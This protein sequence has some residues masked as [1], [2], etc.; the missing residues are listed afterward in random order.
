VANRFDHSPRAEAAIS[1]TS[2]Y[3]HLFNAFVFLSTLMFFQ[4]MAKAEIER[5]MLS[6]AEVKRIVSEK[7]PSFSKNNC[8]LECV[9]ASLAELMNPSK[10]LIDADQYMETLELCESENTNTL[11]ENENPK[12][13]TQTEGRPQL[14]NQAQSALRKFS[15][16]I[17]K[18]VNFELPQVDCIQTIRNYD[19][20]IQAAKRRMD[21]VRDQSIDSGL[22]SPES[23]NWRITKLKSRLS[24]FLDSCRQ[25]TRARRYGFE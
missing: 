9:D 1:R 7:C 8:S 16:P 4:S 19:R 25:N 20:A 13:R 21:F 15:S 17:V 22:P 23:M 14:E 3:L 11:V 5:A 12:P 10:R 2:F 6:K 24:K 18:N